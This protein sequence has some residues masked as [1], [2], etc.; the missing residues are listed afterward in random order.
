MSA[1]TAR[2]KNGQTHCVQFVYGVDL[3]ILDTQYTAAEYPA[4]VG[5]GHGFLPD[6]VRLAM[7]AN[8]KRLVLFHHEPMREDDEID[9]MVAEG[10]RLAGSSALSVTAAAENGSIVLGGCRNSVAQRAA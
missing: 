6:S 3:L 4:K 5:W 7:A 9:A 10:R 1:A 8:V 2:A